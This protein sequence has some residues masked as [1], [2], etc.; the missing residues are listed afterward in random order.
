M[1]IVTIGV[2]VT[3][4]GH[5]FPKTGQKSWDMPTHLDYPYG[6]GV[7]GSTFFPNGQKSWDMPTHLDYPYGRGV[8]GGTF[9]PNGT[10]IMGHTDPPEL[11]L[12]E[13]GWRL[14]GGCVGV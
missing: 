6:R 14:V 2:V 4:G 12:R 9:F 1:V 5:I 3:I 7:Q 13:G 8:Q 10:K 11:P